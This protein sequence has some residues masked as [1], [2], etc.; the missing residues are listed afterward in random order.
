MAITC[1]DC[2]YQSTKGTPGG[3]CPA[4]DSFNLSSRHS[5]PPPQKAR[6]PY[7]LALLI[8]LWG[9]LLLLI[10]QKINE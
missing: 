7:Q 8:A 10:M 3:K 9:Y 1:F 6:K 4:C 5:E 2:G